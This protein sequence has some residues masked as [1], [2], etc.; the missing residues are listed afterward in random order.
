M[1]APPL[2]EG[3]VKVIEAD[4]DIPYQGHTAFSPAHAMADPSNGLMTIYSNDMKSYGMR[5]GVA[6]FLG[7]PRD[8]VR[9][10]LPNFP[11]KFGSCPGMCNCV[12]YL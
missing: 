5:T 6:T 4:Y 3:A 1:A 2:D 9:V 7:I 8:K 10:I 12:S 11:I